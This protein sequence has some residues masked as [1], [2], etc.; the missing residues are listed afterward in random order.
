MEGRDGRPRGRCGR[1]RRNA[2]ISA[3]FSSFSFSSSPCRERTRGEAGGGE[4][5]RHELDAVVSAD[6]EDVVLQYLPQLCAH[7]RD[8]RVAEGERCR[9]ISRGGAWAGRRASIVRTARTTGM[10]ALAK[11]RRRARPGGDR[12]QGELNP[13]WEEAGLRFFLPDPPPRP[14]RSPSSR[15][16]CLRRRGWT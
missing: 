2:S 1:T 3:S 12:L 6:L 4:G 9:P 10:T 14:R 16:P 8:L 11:R 13:R 7:A 5:G 15:R